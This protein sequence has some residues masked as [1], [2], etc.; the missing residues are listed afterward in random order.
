MGLSTITDNRN[1]TWRLPGGILLYCCNIKRSLINAWYGITEILMRDLVD[2]Y[3]DK[4]KNRTCENANATLLLILRVL[5]SSRTEQHIT[6]IILY[7][8]F[9]W[10]QIYIIQINYLTCLQLKDLY[11]YW[12]QYIF[13]L[14]DMRNFFQF[15][16]SHIPYN[17]IWE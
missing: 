1:P 14:Q 16:E 4:M 13:H 10:S 17:V 8:I 9:I 6:L 12:K 3:T 2:S 15:S 11:N 5:R 7:T